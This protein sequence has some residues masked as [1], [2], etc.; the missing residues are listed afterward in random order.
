RPTTIFPPADPTVGDPAEV[1][2]DYTP[3]VGGQVSF[4]IGEQTKTIVIKVNADF[5]DEPNENFRVLLSQPVGATI[6]DGE[7]IAT[8]QNADQ[9]PTLSIDSITVN[10]PASGTAQA[11]F[12]VT[13]SNPSLSEVRVTVTTM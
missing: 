8:I 2:D 1:P 12:T 11:V 5:L 6:T 13:L 9:P 4:A 7:G 3:V 10:E